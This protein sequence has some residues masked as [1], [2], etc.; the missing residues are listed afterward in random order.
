MGLPCGLVRARRAPP[1]NQGVRGALAETSTA[2]T[3]ISS[4][5]L[6]H[7]LMGKEEGVLSQGKRPSTHAGLDGA[8]PPG[9]G[10]QGQPLG[11]APSTQSPNRQL[12]GIYWV[13]QEARPTQS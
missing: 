4:T 10:L 7:A 5:D 13:P 11:P 8:P 1:S 12:L 6:E 2:H 3:P 9:P